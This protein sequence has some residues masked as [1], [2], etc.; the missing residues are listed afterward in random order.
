MLQTIRDHT[1]GWLAAIVISALVLMVALWGISSYFSGSSN[2]SVVATVN[3]MEITKEQF[4]VA[5]EQARRQLQVRLGVNFPIP[6]AQDM[7]IKDQVLHSLINTQVFK[8]AALAMNYHI[9]PSQVDNYLEKIPDFQDKGQFSLAKFQEVMASSWY[10][11]NDLLDLIETNLLIAQPKLGVMISA[12]GLNNEVRQMIDLLAQ[13]RD[14]SYL[15]LDNSVIVAL[16]MPELKTAQIMAY[17][18]AN[19]SEFKTPEKVSIE[20][21]KI[22]LRDIMATIHP[23]A[24]LIKNYYNENINNFV[25]VAIVKNKKTTKVQTLVQVAAKVRSMLIRQKAEEIMASL[26]DKL[27]ELTYEQP[28][29]LQQAAQSLALPINSSAFFTKDKGNQGITLLPKVREAAFSHDVL[30][31]HNN[32]DVLAINP[33][34]II[35]LRVKEHL[36]SSLLPA[37]AV[38]EQI[39]MHLRTT[40]R[41]QQLTAYANNIYSLL[42]DKNVAESAI[43]EKYRLS[44]RKLGYV[45]RYA[46][47]ANSA[48]LDCAFQLPNPVLHK[49]RTS[50]GITALAK[51]G[52]AIVAVHDARSGIS[53]NNKQDEAFKWRLENNN[54]MVEYTLYKQALVQKA[55][56]K[57]KN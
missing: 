37:A 55:Q 22:S 1:Q 26:R 53:A 20:Y 15:L 29:S 33:E 30:A 12:F 52:Y 5:Y 14:T 42:H 3:G 57:I 19:Q 54:S 7:L 39:K 2:N 16:P 31:L 46:K 38:T 51:G 35:V 28:Y 56:I 49:G 17:Y 24:E 11:A 4:T 21:L 36:H 40:I 10:S 25:T 18:Q 6:A 48:V 41:Q 27:A 44:W 8:Q 43:A 45:G 32:S 47:Q 9:A 50:Y 13:E 23:S 34:T